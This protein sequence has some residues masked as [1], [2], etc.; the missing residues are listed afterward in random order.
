MREFFGLRPSLLDDSSTGPLRFD[1]STEDRTYAMNFAAA[2]Q[3]HSTVR[4]KNCSNFNIYF[5]PM[6]TVDLLG[7]VTNLRNCPISRM[8]P[9]CVLRFTGGGKII[10]RKPHPM[11]LYESG[12]DFDGTNL[13]RRSLGTTNNVKGK[14]L[15]IFDKNQNINKIFIGSSPVD[16]KSYPLVYAF[17]TEAK[18]VEKSDTCQISNL[19]PEQDFKVQNNSRNKNLKLNKIPDFKIKILLILLMILCT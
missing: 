3:S 2:R 10:F 17:S 12:T 6:C 13:S 4:T 15:V 1:S 19:F 9:R 7:T 11:K 16:E 18:R 5:C 14:D 8:C